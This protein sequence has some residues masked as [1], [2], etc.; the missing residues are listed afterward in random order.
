M[1]GN[2]I[3]TAKQEK[4]S[5]VF[6]EKYIESIKIPSENELFSVVV[7]VYPD[8]AKNP[9]LRDLWMTTYTKQAIALKYYLKSN[10]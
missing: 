8:L 5:K 4:G 6:F 1:A 3:E 10:R 9:T 7:S 2:A